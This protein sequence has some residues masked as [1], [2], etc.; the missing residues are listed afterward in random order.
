[1]NEELKI[2]IS[3]IIS[4]TN[5]TGA[6]KLIKHNSELLLK[7][8]RLYPFAKNIQELC[9]LLLNDLVSRPLCER[10]GKIEVA[11]LSYKKG[12]QKT[13]KYCNCII[14]REKYKDTCMRKYGVSSVSKLQSVK[15]K[16][17]ETNIRKY[18][19][20]SHNQSSQVKEKKKQ[21]L[22]LNYGVENPTKS[23][24]IKNKIKNTNLER[25]GHLCSLASKSAQEKSKKTCLERYGVE[26]A[27]SSEII[28]EKKKQTFLEHYG[29]DNCFK[30]FDI[31]KQIRETN[32]SKY[33]VS[34]ASKSDIVKAKVRVTNTQNL[35]VPY[36]TQNQN[37]REKCKLTCIEHYGVDNPSKVKDI[38]EENQ[39]KIKKTCLERYGVEVAAMSY[40]VIKKMRQKIFFN[41]LYF[42][43]SL[44]LLYFL[45]LK[46]NNISFKYH[47]L[48]SKIKWLD[49]NNNEHVYFPDFLLIETNQLVEIKG[50][51]F[52]DSVG[53]YFD[54]FSKNNLD[55][56][57]K[58]KAMID[59]N[60]L[61]M[62]KNNL[63]EI[64]INTN[65]TRLIRKF[66]SILRENNDSDFCEDISDINKDNFSDYIK[67]IKY[68]KN[69]FE[70]KNR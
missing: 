19:V 46:R 24:I 59:H 37:V 68:D 32:I 5:S 47:D 25:Y 18:G 42:D 41:G 20:K 10:C 28:K 27:N 52:F 39:K 9:Y 40:E 11:F 16:I 35:G 66:C 29:V 17:I 8:T 26:N 14:S 69:D 2:I 57:L 4:K 33:G 63:I 58:Y 21:T 31:K 50:D 49:S 48:Q 13:C 36:P 70:R 30:N 43:S 7:L 62:R 55:S 38:V 3:D 54:P 22:F 45:Y 51:H 23:D 1:M 34:V 12:Y 6:T 15:N 64:G 44:E 60:V 67:M 56:Q 61:I 53:D 65:N